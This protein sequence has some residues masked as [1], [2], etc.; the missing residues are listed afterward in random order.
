MSVWYF[1]AIYMLHL[2]VYMTS[3]TSMSLSQLGLL[4]GGCGLVHG[5]SF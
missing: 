2:C 5:F 4:H 1:V 3:I